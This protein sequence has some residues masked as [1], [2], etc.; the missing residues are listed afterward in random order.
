MLLLQEIGADEARVRDEIQKL[1]AEFGVRR[2]E[3]QSFHPHYKIQQE[4]GKS[5]TQE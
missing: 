1:Q 3:E 5:T 2:S 4:S